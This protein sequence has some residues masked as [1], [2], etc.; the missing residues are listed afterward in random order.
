MGQVDLFYRFGAALA[1]G[2][3]VGL[4]R[5]YAHGGPGREI[6]AGERTLALMGLVG[7]TAAMAADVLASPWAFV[8]IQSRGDVL[9]GRLA[10][11]LQ[12]QHVGSVDIALYRDDLSE[13]GP[14]PIVRTTDV[15]FP[16]DGTS[17]LLVDDV[18]M[19]GRSV[20]AAILSLIDF[21]RPRCIRLLVLVDRGG[22]ELPIAPDFVGLRVNAER[23]QLVDV[24]LKPFDD[25]DAIVM[26][27]RDASAAP[28]D[29]GQPE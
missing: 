17:V 24:R 21:G 15:N 4:Q 23:D 16:L 10:H 22:R 27:D 11:M 12:P 7:C 3:L 6:F 26:A 25:T 18:L 28:P 13:V 5:E 2:F 1:I 8:G 14:Q 20:R 19:T 29:D 9:A